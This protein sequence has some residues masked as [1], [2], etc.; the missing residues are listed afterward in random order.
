MKVTKNGST[1]SIREV[2]R[3]IEDMR[4]EFNDRLDTLENNHLQHLSDRITALEVRVWMGIGAV[5]AV[6]ILFNLF[7]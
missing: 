7:K 2:Y 4:K 1:A 5:T 3:L 6:S